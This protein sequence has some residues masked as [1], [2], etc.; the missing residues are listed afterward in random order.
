MNA[1]TLSEPFLISAYAVLIIV[2]ALAAG[3]LLFVGT[4]GFVRHLG[5]GTVLLVLASLAVFGT[6]FFALRRG[7]ITSPLRGFRLGLLAAGGFYALVLIVFGLVPALAYLPT[8]DIE[9]AAG[10]LGDVVRI[11]ITES[12]GLPVITGAIGGAFYGW[13]QRP[14]S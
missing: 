8:G 7:P 13:L 4:E 1:K 3:L 5:F 6:A 14:P 2:A 10:Y 11:A 12:H 9:T